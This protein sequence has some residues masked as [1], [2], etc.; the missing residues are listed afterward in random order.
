MDTVRQQ[1]ALRLTADYFKLKE[2]RMAI[3]DME[4]N[5]K[6][7][8]YIGL[9]PHEVHPLTLAFETQVTAIA[10]RFKADLA[11]FIMLG[12]DQ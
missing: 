8:I 7:M 11:N 12:D 10:T 9:S 3:A 2:L 6:L 1:L 4:H 5:A